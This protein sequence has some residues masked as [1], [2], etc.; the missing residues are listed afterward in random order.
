MITLKLIEATFFVGQNVKL[1]DDMIVNFDTDLLFIVPKGTELV[2]KRIYFIEGLFGENGKEA[3]H[4]DIYKENDLR[5]YEVETLESV[6]IYSSQID[7]YKVQDAA[8]KLTFEVTED[9]IKKV[10]TDKPKKE[11]LPPTAIHRD[12]DVSSKQ[13]AAMIDANNEKN[14]DEVMKKELK[15]AKKKKGKKKDKENKDSFIQGNRGR[16]NY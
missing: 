4:Y 15:E 16:S 8:H 3:V 6:N 11:K 5:V 7:I 9:M 13:T 10:K 2:I 12:I 1:R 14:D